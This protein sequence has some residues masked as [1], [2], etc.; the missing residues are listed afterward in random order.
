MKAK[1]G[2]VKVVSDGVEVELDHERNGVNVT[3]RVMFPTLFTQLADYCEEVIEYLVKYEN[4][5]DTIDFGLEFPVLINEL[6]TSPPETATV[7]K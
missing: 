7:Q 3:M 1:Y 5:D 4:F 6:N 2:T